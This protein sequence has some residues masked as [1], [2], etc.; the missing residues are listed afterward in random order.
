MMT[1]LLC[2]ITVLWENERAKGTGSLTQVGQAQASI[3]SFPAS[4]AQPRGLLSRVPASRDPL[5]LSAEVYAVPL[6]L[7]QTVMDL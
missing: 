5:W 6:Y 1:L 7:T 3:L 4:K 2:F